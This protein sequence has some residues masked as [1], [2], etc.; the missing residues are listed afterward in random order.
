MSEKL[1]NIEAIIKAFKKEKTSVMKY[2]KIDGITM[3]CATQV[4]ESADTGIKDITD[5]CKK[6][7]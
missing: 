5:L 2:R 1:N 3:E 7:K 4:S 6:Y